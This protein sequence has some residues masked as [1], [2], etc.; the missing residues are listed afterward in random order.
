MIY[1]RG[2]DGI[3]FSR[4]GK[5]NSGIVIAI[6][7]AKRESHEEEELLTMGPNRQIDCRMGTILTNRKTRRKTRRRTA[8][9]FIGAEITTTSNTSTMIRLE[10]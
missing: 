2:L 7:T 5:G 1:E 10:I 3:S 8:E 6:E 4:M 9:D